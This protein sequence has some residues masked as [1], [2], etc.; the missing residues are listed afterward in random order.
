MTISAPAY[1]HHY[2]GAIF[3]FTLLDRREFVP[4]EGLGWCKIS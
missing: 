2:F 1:D 4:R 3:P